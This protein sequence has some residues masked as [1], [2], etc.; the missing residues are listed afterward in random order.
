MRQSRARYE[1]VAARRFELM[2][3]C[4]GSDGWKWKRTP[5]EQ[6][7]RDV[8]PYEGD[9][10]KVVQA[11]LKNVMPGRWGPSNFNLGV[12][13]GD[14]AGLNYR[15]RSLMCEG[16]PRTDIT[17]EAGRLPRTEYGR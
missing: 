16:Y 4:A 3:N 17:S 13:E 14:L 15:L 2:D 8:V 7:T 6:I 11:V 5:A 9:I 12:T 1:R 10:P